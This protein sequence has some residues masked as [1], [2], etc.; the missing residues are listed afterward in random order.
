MIKP[1]VVDLEVDAILIMGHYYHF[2]FYSEKELDLQ[3]LNFFGKN[4]KWVWDLR[5]LAQFQGS[6]MYPGLLQDFKEGYIKFIKLPPLL[7]QLRFPIRGPPTQQG[8][9]Q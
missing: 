4:Y 5:T 9:N 1:V 2:F 7:V 8:P 6:E 3:Y